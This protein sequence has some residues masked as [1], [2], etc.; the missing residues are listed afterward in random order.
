MSLTASLSTIL[1]AIPAEAASASATI[2]PA[3][4]SPDLSWAGLILLLPAISAVLCGLC[5]ARGVK[6]KLPGIITALSLEKP[7]GKSELEAHFLAPLVERLFKDYPDLEYV[8]DLRA[9][10]APDA[11]TR[12]PSLIHKNCTA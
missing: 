10:Q 2:K 6:G 12:K 5:A 9:G 11:V 1:A 7:V 3:V 8:K 4:A